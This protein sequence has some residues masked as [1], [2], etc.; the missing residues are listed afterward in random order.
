MKEIEGARKRFRSQKTIKPA[1]FGPR[2]IRETKKR[3]FKENIL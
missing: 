2:G 1:A 3:Y